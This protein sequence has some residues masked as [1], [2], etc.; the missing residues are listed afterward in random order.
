MSIRALPGAGALE[1]EAVR[2]PPGRR[3]G[4]VDFP[5]EPVAWITEVPVENPGRVWLALSEMATTTG[6]QPV[7]MPTREL[8]PGSRLPGWSWE[9]SYQDLFYHPVDPREVDRLDAAEILRE[10]WGEEVDDEVVNEQRALFTGHFPGLAPRTEEALTRAETL[11]ALDRFDPAPICLVAADR[12]ADTLAVTGWLATDFFQGPLPFSAVLR[13]WEDRFGARLVQVGPS[14]EFRLLVQRPLRT[15]PEA[16]SIAAEH[17]AFSTTWIG[18][19]NGER[20]DLTEI[21]DIAP[22]VVDSP[23]WGF[24]WD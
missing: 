15:M 13:T 19:G 6:L 16:L 23:I 1:F 22:R 24:W 5:E 11:A 14:A 21:R 10:L 12:P 17:W 9:T 4:S 2:L 3:V 8:P 7:L 20:L 18:E